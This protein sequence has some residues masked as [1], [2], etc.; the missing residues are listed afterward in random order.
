MDKKYPVVKSIDVSESE[1]D[2]Y[3]MENVKKGRKFVNFD[4]DDDI[5]INPLPLNNLTLMNNILLFVNNIVCKSPHMT[6]L[7]F[8]YKTDLITNASLYYFEHFNEI[9]NHY[10]EK[11]ENRPIIIVD[12][13]N[14]A[15]NS[16]F[17]R[18]NYDLFTKKYKD[19]GL[20]GVYKMI[21]DNDDYDNTYLYN[22]ILQM[23]LPV[24]NSDFYYIFVINR[25]KE[26]DIIRYRE[27]TIFSDNFI[28]CNVNCTSNSGKTCSSNYKNDES[29]DYL[30]VLLYITL[31]HSEYKDN[32]FGI[33]SSDNYKWYNSSKKIYYV[34]T[35]QLYKV[36][37][38]S[39]ST[40]K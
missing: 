3:M 15:H 6:A 5:D 18:N 21:I 22:N 10:N 1:H 17:L 9:I 24:I 25:D 38:T 19:S 13:K 39:K 4:D 20:V 33:L 32:L 36:S 2:Q 29:D 12:G 30:C 23:L 26:L 27:L 31:L 35:S 7:D 11:G 8:N 40:K 14:L 28:R 16:G 34:K 37:P